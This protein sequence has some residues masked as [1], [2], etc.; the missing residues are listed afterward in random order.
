M[1][2]GAPDY[3][4]GDFFLGLSNAFRKADIDFFVV[5]NVIEVQR[6]RI[7]K[8]A[9]NASSGLLEVAEPL[10]NCCRALVGLFV[11]AL[12]VGRV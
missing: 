9:I 5:A 8:A 11:D 10:P 12:S 1:A 6:T 7:G 4:L 2:I 3:A